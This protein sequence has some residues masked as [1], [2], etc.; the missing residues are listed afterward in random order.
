MVCSPENRVVVDI[1]HKLPGRGVYVCYDPACF[2]AAV[3]KG[4]LARGFRKSI[5]ETDAPAL[6]EQA[7][8]LLYE[9]LLNHVSMLRKSGHI[10]VGYT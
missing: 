3:G 6:L 8:S 7:R 4:S 1:H 5:V 10:D 9:Q 2:K